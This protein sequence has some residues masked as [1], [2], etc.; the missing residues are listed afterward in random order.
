MKK[1][2]GGEPPTMDVSKF[3]SYPKIKSNPN[4]G[5]LF[6]NPLMDKQERIS[7][8]NSILDETKGKI[9][10]IYW[11]PEELELFAKDFPLETIECVGK[12]ID[13]YSSSGEM[14]HMLKH[15]EG[16]FESILETK[17]E[18]ALEKMNNIINF[19][20]SLGYDKFRRFL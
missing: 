8:L 3:L 14:Y 6:L 12:I 11:I 20:G 13:I 4:T 2:E 9:S 15:F 10:P 18:S 7:L 17:H 16:I 19:L 1:W 5:W